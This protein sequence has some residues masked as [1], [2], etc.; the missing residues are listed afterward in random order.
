MV[1]KALIT[2]ITGQ[3]G[4]YLAKFLLDKGYMVYGI[5]RRLSTP[6]FWRLQHLDIFDKVFLIP[7]DLIDVSSMIEAI[8]ISEPDEIYNLAAQSF[9]GSSF[10][11]PIATGEISGL[12]VTKVL[13]GIRQ[14]NPEIKFYQASSSEMYGNSGSNKPLNENGPFKPVS[15]YAAAKL[16]GFWI[17]RIYREGYGLF[18]CN[19]ILFNHESPLRGLEFVTRK[20]SNA[21]AKISLGLEKELIL[22]NLEA[23]RDW[24]YAPE[25]VEAMWLMLQQNDADDYVIATG[26]PHSVKEFVERAFDLAGLDWRKHVKVDKKFFRPLDVNSLYGDY[27][28][29]ERKLGWQPKV[30]FDRLV[31]IMVKEDL[32]KWEMW[33][34]G[35]RFPW[36]AP[37]YPGENKILS[38]Y[39][40]LER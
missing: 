29:A 25:Y 17:T 1:K 23:K 33:L 26:E 21:V 12:G 39:Y 14:F 27:S 11:Q 31:E 15:P 28:K 22:G 5:Y 20:I 36:D 7:A 19:G 30:K 35:E 8:K 37:N 13:E 34:R 16:Y 3:D 6:N 4:A 10:E 24:G 18:A 38:R 2:G 40:G 32:R 9:V